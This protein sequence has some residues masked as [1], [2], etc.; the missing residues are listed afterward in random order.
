MHVVATTSKTR[1]E[2][3]NETLPR[4]VE[5][6]AQAIAEFQRLGWTVLVFW[7]CELKRPVV[8]AGLLEGPMPRGRP[9]RDD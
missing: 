9:S 3:W 1:Y 7:Q 2:Y 5:R 8:A 4:N 6:D